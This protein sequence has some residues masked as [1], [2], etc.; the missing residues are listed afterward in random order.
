[1]KKLSSHVR[2][3]WYASRLASLALTLVVL[4]QLPLAR[5]DEG[6]W[7]FDNPPRKEWKERYN[8][9]P[10]EAWLEHVR[11]ASVRVEGASASFVSP[12][13]LVMTNQH[14]G[15]S[16]VQKLSTPER[17]L[18]RD[19]FYAGTRTEEMPCADFELSVLISYEDVTGRVKGA[20]KRAS[21]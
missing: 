21:S 12:N 16:A 5:A 1:M 19:G 7:P 20:V 8:F 3:R 13:G 9:D 2:R 4:V 18:T 15:R 14:V 6:M 10:S 17:N 11:L